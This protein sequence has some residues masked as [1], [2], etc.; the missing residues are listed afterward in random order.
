MC[1]I[2]AAYTA[3]FIHKAGVVP[4]SHRLR[5]CD[6][7]HGLAAIDCSNS[8]GISTQQEMEANYYRRLADQATAVVT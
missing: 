5:T 4:R 7:R 6:G 3:F 8:S 2:E 1:H